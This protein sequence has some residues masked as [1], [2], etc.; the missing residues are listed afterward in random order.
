MAS[1]N[2]PTQL[3]SGVSASSSAAARMRGYPRFVAASHTASSTSGISIS[4]VLCGPSPY[5]A[6]TWIRQGSCTIPRSFSTAGNRPYEGE[7]KL[8]A[9]AASSDHRRLRV[10]K[11]A[12]R[13]SVTGPR[14]V[15]SE[16]IAR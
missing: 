15:A 7:R 6:N 11:S 5:L 14:Q 2:A 4:A 3:T 8:Y 10:K 9:N 12:N 13:N 1:A 16:T